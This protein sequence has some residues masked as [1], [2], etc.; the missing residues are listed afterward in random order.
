MIKLKEGQTVLDVDGNEYLIEK[1]DFLQ[2]KDLAKIERLPIIRESNNIPILN[3]YQDA[4]DY[5][6][7]KSAQLGKN[8]FLSSP[9]YKK[10]YPLVSK[11]YAT[12]KELKRMELESEAKEAMEKANVRFGDRVHYTFLDMFMGATHYTG[13]VVNRNG[14]PYVKYDKGLVDFKGNKSGRWHKGWKKL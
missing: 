9:E 6:E 5:I 7:M 2:E 12:E 8:E 13:V 4:L 3:S 1:G 14:I 11:L 10:L